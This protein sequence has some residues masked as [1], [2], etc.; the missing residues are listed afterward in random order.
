MTKAN[1]SEV[2]QV[3]IGPKEGCVN[4]NFA[5]MFLRARSKITE[6]T[7]TKNEDGSVTISAAAS[8][9][10]LVGTLRKFNFHVVIGK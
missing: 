4:P 3:V 5:A 6:V 2:A 9:R 7:D 10:R 8:K 1:S